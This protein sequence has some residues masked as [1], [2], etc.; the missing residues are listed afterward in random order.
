MQH[1][2]WIAVPLNSLTLILNIS[3]KKLVKK[4]LLEKEK[5]AELET[6]E[7][8]TKLLIMKNMLNIKQY[9]T[10]SRYR[11]IQVKNVLVQDSLVFMLFNSLLPGLYIYKFIHSINL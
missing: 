9:K 11:N 4:L 6:L 5:I 3:I 1:L 8:E 7:K 2:S 10:L